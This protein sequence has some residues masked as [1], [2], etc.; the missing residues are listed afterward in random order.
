MYVG[1]MEIQ[2]RLE[3]VNAEDF[4]FAIQQAT[5]EPDNY[6]HEVGRHVIRLLLQAKTSTEFEAIANTVLA[7]TGYN[8]ESILDFIEDGVYSG[9]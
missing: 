8:V 4:G 1:D 5:N 2:K 7:I 9:E 3:D 6:S